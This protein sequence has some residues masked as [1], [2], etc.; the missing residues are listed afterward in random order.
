MSASEEGAG[1]ETGRNKWLPFGA[2]ASELKVNG[3]TLDRKGGDLFGVNPIARSVFRKILLSKASIHLSIG[4]LFSLSRNFDLGNQFGLALGGLLIGFDGEVSGR[5]YVVIA[6]AAAFALL[7]WIVIRII[8]A[9]SP[10]IG[11][12]I[13]IPA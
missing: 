2:I 6:P 3:R 9:L 7:C 1:L 5:T 8:G 13:G 4:R 11:G 12:R 10:A